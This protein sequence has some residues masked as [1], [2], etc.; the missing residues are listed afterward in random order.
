MIALAGTLPPTRYCFQESSGTVLYRSQTVRKS[1]RR[2][3]ELCPLF[4]SLFRKLMDENGINAKDLR[5]IGVQVGRFEEVIDEDPGK[6]LTRWL[7]REA[8]VDATD[9]LLETVPQ[10][11]PPNNLSCP[12][13]SIVAIDMTDEVI[14]LAHGSDESSLTPSQVLF[15]ASLPPDLAMEQR[16]LLLKPS[17]TNEVGRHLTPIANS[18]RRKIASPNKS[19]SR[20]RKIKVGGSTRNADNK[21]QVRMDFLIKLCESE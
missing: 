13:N 3:D 14:D 12:P 8:T 9:A 5:G 4:I 10:L 15:L 21:I 1:V 19:R 11:P 18:P 7:R 17:N 20:Q 6:T 16:R 2:E